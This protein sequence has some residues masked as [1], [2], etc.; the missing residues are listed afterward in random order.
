MDNVSGFVKAINIWALKPHRP[1]FKAVIAGAAVP[2][3]PEIIFL[4]SHSLLGCT[5]PA[6]LI[7]SAV[8]WEERLQQ[9]P[10]PFLTLPAAAGEHT[11]MF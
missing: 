5:F 9:L 11:L 2:E 7:S 8:C 4:K 6:H 10:F 3:A 1:V